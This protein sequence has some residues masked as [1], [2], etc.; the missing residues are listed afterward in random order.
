MQ[1]DEGFG[2]DGPA[3]AGPAHCGGSSLVCSLRGKST[4]PSVV[5]SDMRLQNGGVGSSTVQ[6]WRQFNLL[7]LNKVYLNPPTAHS[8]PFNSPKQTVPLPPPSA[9]APQ[10][11]NSIKRHVGCR[12]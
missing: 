11:L 1:G 12:C 2:E 8:T 6:L 5:V 7:T 4:F 9:L 3:N 10:K